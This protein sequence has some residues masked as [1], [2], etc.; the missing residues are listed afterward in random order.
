[1]LACIFFPSH[2]YSQKDLD[3]NIKSLLDF[4]G[5]VGFRGCIPGCLD[6]ALTVWQGGKWF[7]GLGAGQSPALA[8]GEAESRTHPERKKNKQNWEKIA[9]W[10]CQ[11]PVSLTMQEGMG[12]SGVAFDGASGGFW[13][14]PSIC[15]T[16]NIPEGCMTR[17]SLL[18]G[19]CTPVFS[20]IKWGQEQSYFMGF[21]WGLNEQRRI[22][23]VPKSTQHTVKAW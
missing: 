6:Y 21:L 19:F 18:H 4:T 14:M 9:C 8:V 7:R 3:P 20:P 15:P 17:G 13:F 11:P 22:Y 16:E 5:E 10:I 23:Q 1:M 2:P 12:R